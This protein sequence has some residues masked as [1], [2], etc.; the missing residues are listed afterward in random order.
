M[1]KYILGIDFGHGQTSAALI[2]TDSKGDVFDIIDF[3]FKSGF[4]IPTVIF[5]RAPD[6][7]WV[8]NPSDEDV[9]QNPSDLKTNFKSVV[10]DENEGINSFFRIFIKAFFE[11]LRDKELTDTLF[12]TYGIELWHKGKPQF[13]LYIACPPEWFEIKCNGKTQAEKFREFVNNCISDLGVCVKEV[14]KEPEAALIGIRAEE[15]GVLDTTRA[16]LIDYGSSTVDIYYNGQSW[17]IDGIGGSLI[18]RKI[19]DYM[20]EHESHAQNAYREDLDNYLLYGLRTKKEEFYSNL[21]RGKKGVRF[22]PSLRVSE[23]PPLVFK[24]KSQDGYTVEDLD[25]A[26]SQYCNSLEIKLDKFKKENEIEDVQYV[27]LTGGSSRVSFIPKV[28]S[29]VFG[30]S[31]DNVLVRLPDLA[32]SRGLAL[33]GFKPKVHNNVDDIEKKFHNIEKAV[34]NTNCLQDLIR[35]LSIRVLW[36]P[37]PR[38]KLLN[39]NAFYYNYYNLDGIH[40]KNYSNEDAETE[41]RVHHPILGFKVSENPILLDIMIEFN[42]ITDEDLFVYLSSPDIIGTISFPIIKGK[43]SHHCVTDISNCIPSGEEDKSIGIYLKGHLVKR[44]VLSGHK[45]CTDFSITSGSSNDVPFY[46]NEPYTG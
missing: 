38:K 19:K 10:S 25:E 20:I 16:L 32:V 2:K 21:S 40:I 17:T 13:D 3:P 27:I 11:K 29:K 36:M 31:E 22:N 37:V 23:T 46:V 43:D 7:P 4:T 8:I 1:N 44:I 15:E 33:Y 24:T 5:R 45:K 26:L 14:M 41:F 30:I 42:S 35:S 34:D 18:E 6:S 39:F 28:I 12:Y 9:I